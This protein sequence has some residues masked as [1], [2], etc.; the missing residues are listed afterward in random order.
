MNNGFY[1]RVDRLYRKVE[2]AAIVLAGL[3]ILAVMALVSTDA[4]LRRGLDYPL[5]FQLP[6]SENYLLVALTMLSLAW[7]YRRGGTIRVHI[8]I[9]ALPRTVSVPILR[10]G[11][12]ISSIYI[13]ALGVLAYSTFHEALVNNEVQMGVI[14]WPV[15][16]SWF[17]IPV[18]CGLLAVRL[19]IEVFKPEDELLPRDEDVTDKEI[20]AE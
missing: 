19:A 2:L 14:D 9:D 20:T 13:L 6:L 15:A 10:I 8:L 11:L 4:V 17:W 7:G 1:H 3:V 18:G 5:T 16:W 12:G